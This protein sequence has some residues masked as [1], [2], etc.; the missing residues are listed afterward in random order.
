MNKKYKFKYYYRGTLSSKYL[1]TRKPKG[2]YGSIVKVKSQHPDMYTEYH[3]QTVCKVTD[4]EDELKVDLGGFKFNLNY[5]QAQDLYTALYL[6][7]HTDE[8]ELVVKQKKGC[9]CK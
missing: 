3:N 4:T 1:V 2:E 5:A 7:E 9:S 6:F 8:D